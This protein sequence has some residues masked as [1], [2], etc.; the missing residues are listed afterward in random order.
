MAAAC[1]SA[2][3]WDEYYDMSVLPNDPSLGS[4][5][6]DLEGDI[7]QCSIS[8]GVLDI[9]HD[10]T[11]ASACF[12]KSAASS[13]GGP[14]TVEAEVEAVSGSGTLLAAGNGAWPTFVWLYTDHL[15]ISIGAGP[16][17]NYSADMTQFQTV[18]DR[19]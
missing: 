16:A 17:M 4:S 8:N 11:N 13:Q 9:D 19:R 12:T 3:A 2:L 10:T 5:A 15:G 14:V 7:S 18:R 1:G 6:W